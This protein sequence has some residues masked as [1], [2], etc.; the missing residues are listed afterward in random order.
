MAALTQSTLEL[1]ETGGLDITIRDISTR[2]NVPHSLVA[3]YFG[4]KEGLITEAIATTLPDDQELAASL[5]CPAAA[6]AAV[7]D[8]MFDRPERIRIL[9]QL[10]NSGMA[11]GEIRSEAP[12]LEALVRLIEEQSPEVP[13]PRIAAA[14]VG[15]LCGGWLIFES[16]VLEHTG[17]ADEDVD[18]VRAQVRELLPRL[19]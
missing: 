9:A 15:A 1:L 3:R 13:D 17:L 2:A 6:A 7:F 10:L 12:L 8:S 11:S 5:D 14:A 18:K 16:F 4:S 19:L